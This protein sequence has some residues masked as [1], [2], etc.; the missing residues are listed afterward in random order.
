M[1]LIFIALPCLLFPA[2]VMADDFTGFSVNFVEIGNAGNAADTTSRGA[3]DYAYRISKYEVSGAMIDA[4]NA[5]GGGPEITRHEPYG[6]TRP[7]TLV[8]WNEAARF[9][10][11][12]NTSTGHSAAYKFTT[13][14]ANDNIALWESA[15]QGYDSANPF[16]N[17]GAYYFL[18]SL[19]EWYKAAY[20]DPEAN[21]GTGGYWD[22]P[23]GSDTPPAPVSGGT[24]SG[25]SVH[26]QSFLD[27]PAEVDNAGGLSPFGTMAQ[28]GNVDEWLETSLSG[29]NDSGTS[30][31]LLR[32]G[33]WFGNVANQS[34]ASLSWNDPMGASSLTGFRVASIPEPSA[35]IL[36]L[37]GMAAVAFRRRR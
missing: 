2:V 7:A 14:G 18:P 13:G 35:A 27:P 32:G 28:G 34:S 12:L 20:Y 17:S 23:T 37:L 19:D 36:I 11:W 33:I 10:N 29:S 4:Y 26:S 25:T 21:G 1:K 16:R 6:P 31:R 22:Y 9:V 30:D 5:L 24:A 3:V 8:S 15:D